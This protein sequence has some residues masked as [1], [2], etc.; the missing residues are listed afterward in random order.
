MTYY[1]GGSLISPPQTYSAIVDGITD[2]GFSV[3]GYSRGVF[4][5]L[6]AIDLPMGYKSGIQATKIINVIYEKFSQ[7]N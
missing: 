5:A 7:R 1:P 4:P 6:E 2:M 3:L